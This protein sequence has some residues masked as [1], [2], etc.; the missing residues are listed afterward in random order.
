MN[1]LQAGIIGLGVGEQHAYAYRRHPE[2]R[3]VAL[4]DFSEEKL[5]RAQKKFPG[6]TLTKNA[7]DL[8][9]NPDI[10]IISIAS[11]D[12]AHA[13]QVVASLESGKNVFVEKPL[14]QTLDQATRIKR[15]WESRKDLQK[16]GCNLVLRE[17]PLYKWIRNAIRN[18]VFGD[19]YAFDGEYLYGRL[20]KITDEWRS[21][22]DNYSVMEGGGIHM[23]DLMLWLTG[24]RPGAVMSAGNRIS[25]INTSFRY[26]DYVTSVLEFEN[27]MIGRITA[28]FGCVHR[29]QHVVRIFGTKATFFYD[30]AGPRMF[31]SRNPTD[32]PIPVR[33]N[34][35]PATKGDLI[36]AFVSAILNKKDITDETQML[37]DGI[38]ISSACDRS[39]QT[40]R[41]ELINYL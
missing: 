1:P 31:K 16:L 13:N 32:A 33:K 37:F 26:N 39:V 27:G 8:F 36:P 2:C 18:G 9:S 19:I 21:R 10:D 17:A 29:H 22:I 5:L 15:L 7:E 24:T 35:L 11:Y 38:S 40:Q 41:R 12:D 34:P 4:C 20:H 3:V 25:T 14:C 28:N 23:I 6:A 30:D